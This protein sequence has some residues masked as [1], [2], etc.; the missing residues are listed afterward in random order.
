MSRNN[1]SSISQFQ[2]KSTTA[3]VT[4]DSVQAAINACRETTKAA[5]E[6]KLPTILWDQI[7]A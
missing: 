4:L 6:K 7:L 1:I 2:Q 3:A 5:N